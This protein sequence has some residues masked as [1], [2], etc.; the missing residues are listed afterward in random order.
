M[1]GSSARRTIAHARS[2]NDARAHL[3]ARA[4]FVR[5]AAA[6]KHDLLRFINSRFDEFVPGVSSAGLL[7]CFLASVTTLLGP[8]TIEFISSVRPD[9]A[10][11]TWSQPAG[12]FYLFVAG[13]GQF[14]SGTMS[15][16]S[17]AIDAVLQCVKSLKVSLGGSIDVHSWVDHITDQVS[18][19]KD[20]STSAWFER[21]KGAPRRGSQ[22]A[23]A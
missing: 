17:N 19:F 2:E 9:G 1:T 6:N 20:G 21:I 15:I 12:C 3:T 5:G 8:I 4:S 11:S 22:A 10:Q 13:P 7:L 16:C 23:A 14:K 18:I